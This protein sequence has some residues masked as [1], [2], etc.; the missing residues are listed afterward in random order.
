MQALLV[1]W[2][3][4]TGK[5]VIDQHVIRIKC[6]SPV[7]SPTGCLRHEKCKEKTTF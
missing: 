7:C 1:P 4:N 2:R 5:I 3:E 6:A